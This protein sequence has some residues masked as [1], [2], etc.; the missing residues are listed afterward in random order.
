MLNDI[1]KHF[2]KKLNNK[3]LTLNLRHPEEL[4]FANFYVKQSSENCISNNV[5]LIQMLKN[6]IDKNY[7]F[8]Y[9]W[10]EHGCGKTHLLLATNN[11]YHQSQ[12][13]LKFTYFPMRELANVSENILN[14]LEHNKIVLLDDIDYVINSKNWNEALFHLFNRIQQ[15][16]NFL[17]VTATTK[18]QELQCNLPDLQSRLASGI[19]AKI[20]SL[21]DDEKILALQII[22]QQT[23][24]MLTEK[25]AKFLINHCQRDTTSLF[26]LLQHLDQASMNEQ[27][28][29]TIPFI[30]KI[31]N[32]LSTIPKFV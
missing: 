30:K 20:Q 16:N 12:K 28:N 17:I 21:K 15:N 3:Q 11:Y 19:T 9:L 23:G 13:N 14:N 27:R 6:T 7:N 18:P 5:T 31:L 26:Q 2:T 25:T 32:D 22:A 4:S 10:G 29:L 1:N 24:L 8:I